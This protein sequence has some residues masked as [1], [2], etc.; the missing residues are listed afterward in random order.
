MSEERVETISIAEG[1]EINVH[2]DLIERGLSMLGMRRSG[3]SYSSGV[4]CE[5]LLSGGQPIIII[6]LMSEYYTLREHFPILIASLGSPE[7]ADIARV[8]P[9]QA[10]QLAEFVVS[11]GLSLILDLRHGRMANRFEFL[12]DFL[13]ALYHVEEKH[14]IPYVLVMDEAHKITPEKGV[15]RIKTVREA[16]EKVEEWVYEIGQTGGHLGI[17]FIVIARRSAE[18][19]KMTLAQTEVRIIHKLVDPTDLN[20]ISTW[21]DSEQRERVRNFKK[22]EAV[23]VGLE[24]PIF[25]KVKERICTHGGGTPLAKPLETPDLAEAIGKLTDLLSR[26]EVEIPEVEEAPVERERLK[27][28]EAEKGA[29]ETRNRELDSKLSE[30]NTQLEGLNAMVEGYKK[31]IRELEEKLPEAEEQQELIRS[32][33]EEIRR[34]EEESQKD[35]ALIE[36]LEGQLEEAAEDL[37]QIEEL[38]GSLMD[39]RDVTLDLARRFGVELIPSDMQKIINERDH[40]QRRYEELQENIDKKS[41]LTA[42]VLQDAGVKDWIRFAK[43]LLSGFTSRRSAHSE[44]LKKI[45][46]TD[47]TYLFLPEEFPEASVGSGTV[48]SYLND[49]ESQGLVLKHERGKL[50]RTAYSNGLPLWVSQNVRRIRLDAPDEA[51]KRVEEELKNYVLRGR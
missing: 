38:R 4:I 9:E 33:E 7:H 31:R 51:V 44:V 24:E 29:L 48:A 30:A 11:N 12:G 26:P 10:P 17:G 13:E 16:Q 36:E 40:F 46:A 37:G 50:G 5:E 28:L 41:R 45:V 3:K 22:G 15:R 47:P 27:R 18:I 42:D 21:L 1:F 8:T 34:L 49:F 23:V 6:D 14:M 25:I 43:N 20:Y 2:E 32:H 35:K 39:W 19:S